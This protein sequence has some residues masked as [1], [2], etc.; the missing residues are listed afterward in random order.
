MADLVEK[1]VQTIRMFFKKAQDRM[2]SEMNSGTEFD[3]Q[4]RERIMARIDHELKRLDRRTKK[5]TRN[6]AS[7]HYKEGR[8][9]S[10]KLV[11]SVDYK[12]EREF[13]D[14]VGAFDHR[15]TRGKKLSYNPYNRAYEN[16][17]NN[18]SGETQRKA[19]EALMR[20]APAN[21]KLG[22]RVQDVLANVHGLERPSS[23]D[24]PPISYSFSQ[25]DINAIEAMA[26]DMY[27]NF[28]E[29]LTVVRKQSSSLISMAQKRRIR[30][31]MANGRITRQT[32]REISKE[33]ADSLKKGFVALKDKSGK[34]WSLDAYA[35]ML[36]RTKISE[37]TNL[38]IQ[39]QLSK[40]GYDLVQVT[41]HLT[42]C[43]LCAPWEGRILSISGKHPD[44]PSTETAQKEGLLHPNCKHRYVPY[45]E[46]FAKETRAWSQE[47]QKYVSRGEMDKLIERYRK[48]PVKAPA[49]YVAQGITFT[50]EQS[51]FLRANDIKVGT[52]VGREGRLMQVSGAYN[53]KTHNIDLDIDKIKDIS[54]KI[55]DKQYGSKVFDHEFGHALDFN[56]YK[57]NKGKRT[58]LSK[59]PIFDYDLDRNGT[60]M[61]DRSLVVRNRVMRSSDTASRR[62]MRSWGDE[63]WNQYFGD[64]INVN[65]EKRRLSQLGYNFY[66]SPQELF[67]ESYNIYKNHGD[68]LR[69]ASPTL[70]KYFKKLLS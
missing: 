29:S 7:R 28:A 33:I 60:Y 17:S 62:V 1:D 70:H 3:K 67:A 46:A 35:E 31:I 2:L 16:I 32:R 54:K 38:G 15:K 14:K 13:L 24:L 18:L 25:L 19:Y 21:D 40:S 43:D 23:A 66:S 39:N 45:H 36:A 10:I 64:G 49:Q 11:S 30:D 26:D 41:R 44:Y 52:D 61:R 59:D 50:P 55:G 56:Y 27:L 4:E 68:Y 58:R 37:A 63:Q 5:Y 53:T 34:T 57:V 6:V 51:E 8:D 42:D 9:F 48:M 65:G 47:A 69:G 20:I 22:K 12:K